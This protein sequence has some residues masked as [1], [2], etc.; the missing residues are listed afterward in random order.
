VRI[1][2]SAR[3]G[4]GLRRRY[5]EI[6]FRHHSGTIPTRPTAVAAVQFGPVGAVFLQTVRL[7]AVAYPRAHA[8]RRSFTDLNGNPMGTATHVNL[9]AGQATFIDLPGA[10]I[11]GDSDRPSGAGK[12]PSGLA[13]L[14]TDSLPPSG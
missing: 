3:D 10:A 6:H 1:V 13:P 9:T 12:C 11:V 4:G 2:I 5:R 8:L 14:F 7:N